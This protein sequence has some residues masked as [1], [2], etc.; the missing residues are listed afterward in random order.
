MPALFD[1]VY[2]LL[3]PLLFRMD[4]ERAHRLTLAFL[5]H[6]PQPRRRHDPPELQTSAF[7]LRFSNPLGLAAGL[8]KDGLAIRAWEAI[9]FGFAE[10]GT[11]TPRAQSGNP[12]P[13]VWRIEEHR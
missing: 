13:R 10:L 12:P 7:G 4:P 8:D 11:V 3:R 9:G 6:A 1:Y 5:R 2:R